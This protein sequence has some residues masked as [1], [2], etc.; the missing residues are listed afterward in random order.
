MSDVLKLLTYLS[1]SMMLVYSRSYLIT[2]GLFTGEFLS[3]GVVRHAGH[4][5]DDLRQQLRDAVHR[6]RSTGPEP[7]CDG[8]VATRLRC[9]H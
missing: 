5:G 2:R 8:R 3:A 6:P 9:G 1:V 7:V 4:D